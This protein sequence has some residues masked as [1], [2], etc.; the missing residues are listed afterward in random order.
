MAADLVLRLTNKYRTLKMHSLNVLGNS[1]QITE[2]LADREA[3]NRIYA[4]RSSKFRY[5]LATND[6]R[7]KI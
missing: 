5:A 7:S 6:I 3:K 2:H 1:R 4:N